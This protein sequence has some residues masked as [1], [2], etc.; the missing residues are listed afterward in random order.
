MGGTDLV[1]LRMY[2]GNP[3]LKRKCMAPKC[4]TSLQDLSAL[5]TANP[6]GTCNAECFDGRL[7]TELQGQRML[8]QLNCSVGASGDVFAASS[9]SSMV[10]SHW[11]T[12]SYTK[13]YGIIAGSS[14]G[15]IAIVACLCCRRSCYKFLRVIFL[16]QNTITF[17][18][19]VACSVFS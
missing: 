16:V 3:V 11:F 2:N 17:F 8:E 18:I 4:T 5:S 19:G 10:I 15:F 13:I 9:Q 7:A 6:T 12:G 14:V 1:A